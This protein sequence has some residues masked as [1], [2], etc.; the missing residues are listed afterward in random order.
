MLNYLV[1]IIQLSFHILFY[2]SYI[3]QSSLSCSFDYGFCKWQPV[4]NYPDF[5]GWTLRSGPGYD[6]SV[7]SV[8]HHGK[9]HIFQTFVYQMYDEK[10]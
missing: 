9:I 3:A 6:P 10:P 5:C 4:A 1:N 7:D 2:L 8:A